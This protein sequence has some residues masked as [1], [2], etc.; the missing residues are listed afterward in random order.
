MEV[1]DDEYACTFTASM[2][3]ET[4]AEAAAS[5]RVS[6]FMCARAVDDSSLSDLHAADQRPALESTVF[7]VIPFPFSCA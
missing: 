2:A 7:P 5:D 1:R 4:S 6:A 3:C